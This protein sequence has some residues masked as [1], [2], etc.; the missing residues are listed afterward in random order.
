MSYGALEKPY[1]LHGLY[2]ETYSPSALELPYNLTGFYDADYIGGDLTQKAQVVGFD[3][4]ELGNL[5]LSYTQGIG[6]SSINQSEVG[7]PN[8]YLKTR[9]LPLVGIVSDGYGTA[10]IVNKNQQVS[11]SG[12]DTSAYGSQSIYNLKQFVEPEGKEQSLYGT[13]YMIGGVRWLL[14]QG[15]ESLAS[16]RLLVINTKADQYAIPAGIFSQSISAPVVTPIIIHTFGVPPLVMGVPNIRDPAIKPTGLTHSDCGAATIWFHTRSLS[17][18]GILSYASGYPRVADPTQLIQTQSLLTSAI[19]GDTATRNLSS[20]ISAPAIIAGSFSDY[21]TLTNSNRYYPIAGINSL[22]IGVLTIANETPELL[23]TGIA[24]STIDAPAIGFAISS[25]NPSGFDGLLLG[26]P[27][28]D[29][30]PELLVRGYQSS[31]TGT[32]TI[33]HKNRILEHKGFDSHATGSA[34]AWFRYRYIEHDKSW[35]SHTVGRATLT[36][37]LR[38]VIGHGFVRE[39]YGAAWVSRSTRWIEPSAVYQEFASNHLVGGTQTIQPLGYEATQW[40]T[41]IIPES[42]SL[43][44]IGF[45]GLWGDATVT[46]FTRYIQPKG[47]ISVGQQPQERWGDARLFNSVQYIVQNFAGDNGLVPPKWSDWQSVENRNKTI[48]AIGV[49]SQKFGYS[50]IDNNAAPVWPL[51]IEPPID[52][53]AMIAYAIRSI[54]LGGI[55]APIISSWGVVYNDARVIAPTSR[56]HTL[57]GEPTVIN[58]RREYRNVGRIDSLEAGLPMVAERIRTIDIERRYSIEPPQIELPTIDLWTRYINC[59]GYDTSAHGLLSLSIHFSIIAPKWSYRDKLGSPALRNVT[60]ELLINGHNSNEYG[61]THIRTQWREVKAQG[62]DTSLIGQH[63][64]EDTKRAVEV[65]GLQSSLSSQRHTVTQMGTNPYVLQRIWLDDESGYGKGY[66]IS[67]DDEFKLDR[68]PKPILQ[69]NVLEPQGFAGRSYFGTPMVYI[70]NIVVESGIGID[71]VSK[72]LSVRNKNNMIGVSGISTGGQNLGRPRL[73]PHRIYAVVEAPSQAVTNHS[74]GVLHYVGE[75]I[76]YK[77]PGEIFGVATVE[78]TIRSICP[79]WSHTNLS[80]GKPTLTL[81]KQTI[82]PEPFRL[83]RFGVPSIPFTLQT[84]TLYSGIESNRWGATL[85]R[86]PD[87]IGVQYISHSAWDSFTT[88][89]NRIE[90]QHREIYPR[91]HDSLQAGTKKPDDKPYMWQGLRI[92]ELMPTIAGCGDVSVFGSTVIGL[93]I[94]EVQAQGFNAFKSEHDLTQ[95]DGRMNVKYKVKNV[96]KNTQAT[97]TGTDTLE[98]GQVSIRL[99]QHFIRPDGNSD[100]FRKG[101]F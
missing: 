22:S 31:V 84:I 13:A 66:G 46:L 32:T 93:L 69:Q 63:K 96:V 67:S 12:V 78:S 2:L 75:V 54:L 73:S 98:I 77:P 82:A 81:R 52:S 28:L 43:H 60:P 21:A 14:Q 41:R 64:I 68:M 26:R 56:T 18:N 80:Y 59:T 51:G 7:T 53:K 58:T 1:R 94:R 23:P 35:Q 50:Q 49:N 10:F 40:L 17:P 24:A 70:N 74:P 72:S 85:V 44:P 57:A 48:G 47:Y 90:N 45:I 92:G 29:K 65:R 55:E 4:S 15:F 16:G 19:F 91:G 83:S 6:A 87:Y 3:S 25:I 30:N 62:D 61:D 95:F 100:Q 39:A 89:G 8:S 27:I 38:E 20:V 33:W 79:M 11:V 97:T 86:R 71:G 5:S 99:N 42:Q 76:G 9:Y 88:T 37:G 36:H 101:A 34:T